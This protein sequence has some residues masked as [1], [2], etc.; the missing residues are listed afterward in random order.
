MKTYFTFGSGFSVIVVVDVA[1][2]NGFSPCWL[3]KQLSRGHGVKSHCF[4]FD[5]TLT[6]WEEEETEEEEDSSRTSGRT[7]A[8]TLI[9]L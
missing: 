3:V 5:V 1:A 7:P 9:S 2:A 6:S 4:S 8:S